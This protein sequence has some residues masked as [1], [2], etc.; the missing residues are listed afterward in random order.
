[1]LEDFGHT[2]KNNMLSGELLFTLALTSEV[3]YVKQA[4]DYFKACLKS[5]LHVAH[6][7]RQKYSS[8]FVQLIL[9]YLV[10]ISESLQL[11]A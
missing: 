8:R 7:Q 4:F 2:S 6:A 10:F 3:F 11:T 9:P 5:L 1:V